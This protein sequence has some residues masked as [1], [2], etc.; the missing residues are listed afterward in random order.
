MIPNFRGN[1]FTF[2]LNWLKISKILS[3]FAVT[4]LRSN[5]V[6][7]KIND[8]AHTYLS[9]NT[10][11][12]RGGIHQDGIRLPEAADIQDDY[13]I[14]LDIDDWLDDTYIETMLTRIVETEAD[15]VYPQM[16]ENYSLR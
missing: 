10:C 13:M 3:K 9:G 15:I 2:Y 6:L 1:L 11:L 7:A 16:K 14:P 5:Q 4:I 8:P 12:Q